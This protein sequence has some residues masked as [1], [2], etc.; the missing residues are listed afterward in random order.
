MEAKAWK[1]AM[2][3]EIDVLE[4]NHTWDIQE[5]PPGKIALGY[6]WVYKIKL[7]ADGTLEGYKT[8]LVVLW[9][10]QVEGIDYGETFAPGAKMTSVRNFLD[11]AA[12]Q[13]FEV[14]QMDVHNAFL[15]GDLEE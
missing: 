15:H 10:N 9:N 14:H 11:I 5:L 2:R 1:D 3:F 6:K 4:Q 7:K 8:R 12:K 13:D